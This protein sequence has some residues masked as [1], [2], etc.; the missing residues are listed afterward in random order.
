MAAGAINP[1]AVLSIERETS[2]T[3][4]IDANAGM[5][6]VVAHKS[7]GLALDK[8]SRAGGVATVIVKN[9]SHF[10]AG[11][12]YAL[13]AAEADRI[14]MVF[15]TTPV[16]MNASGSRRAALGN[17]PI[18]YG[19]PGDDMPVVLDISMSLTAGSVI[20]MAI[21]RDLP[22]VP[23]TATNMEGLPTTDPREVAGLVPIADYKGYG[24]ALLCDLIAGSLSGTPWGLAGPGKPPIARIAEDVG[25]SP[26]FGKKP[27]GIGHTFIAIDPSVFI[28]IP[29]LKERVTALSNEIRTAP[30]ATGVERIFVPGEMEHFREQD[31]T[32]HGIAFDQV[33]HD[34]LRGMAADHDCMPLFD[35]ALIG[36]EN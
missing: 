18:A 9:S 3:A 36:P 4:L 5:G 32:E 33:T 23:G 34:I 7:M 29:E 19:F 22:L 28:S 14:G 17:G 1:T 10:G 35:Q 25:G 24:L 31:Y 20:T 2:T 11:G 21:A 6:H 12:L 8:A 16:N 13:Q 27:T 26:D 30:K 15:T